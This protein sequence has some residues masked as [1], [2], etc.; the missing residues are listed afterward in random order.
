MSKSSA[1]TVVEVDPTAFVDDDLEAASFVDEA[2][3]DEDAV[4]VDD[5][6]ADVAEEKFFMGFGAVGGGIRE[7]DS[8]F[9][10]SSGTLIACNASTVALAACSS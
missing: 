10:S 4:A 5:E 6:D 9:S 2:I 8:P 3:G 1:V 7:C